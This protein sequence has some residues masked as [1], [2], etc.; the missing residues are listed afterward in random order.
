M[1]GNP[2]GRLKVAF[3]SDYLQATKD[4]KDFLAIR[5]GDFSTKIVQDA[6]LF[7]PDFAQRESADLEVS[8]SCSGRVLEQRHSTCPARLQSG[9][10]HTRRSDIGLR[11][12]TET[13][14]YS[15]TTSRSIKSS[16][17]ST[18]TTSIT[19]RNQRAWHWCSRSV[20]IRIRSCVRWTSARTTFSRRWNGARVIR[21]T[22]RHHASSAN[23]VPRV[24]RFEPA[25]QVAA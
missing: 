1:A 18:T 13:S 2:N 24:Y 6:L 9:G 23:H 20:R 10:N 3:V 14:L 16:S 21:P 7:T 17:G 22:P 19:P 11:L 15:P 5:S 25:E 12:S 8:R 4:D